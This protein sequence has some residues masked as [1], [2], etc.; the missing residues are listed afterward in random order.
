MFSTDYILL[1]FWYSF[2]ILY[3]QFYVMTIGTQTELVTGENMAVEF[4]IALCTVSSMGILI[5]LVMDKF[6]FAVVVLFYG[7]LLLHHFI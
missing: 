3:L 2:Y 4:T 6:G 1:N 7:C 5:G